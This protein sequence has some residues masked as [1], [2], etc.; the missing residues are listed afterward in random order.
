M[1]KFLLVHIAAAIF[2]KYRWF[3]VSFAISLIVLMCV[4]IGCRLHH[5]TDCEPQQISKAPDHVSDELLQLVLNEDEHQAKAE[6]EPYTLNANTWSQDT[7][8]WL[9]GGRH[10]GYMSVNPYKKDD[11]PMLDAAYSSWLEL[12]KRSSTPYKDYARWWLSRTHQPEIKLYDAWCH[13]FSYTA[14]DVP[15]LDSTVEAYNRW[16]AILHSEKTISTPY[17]DYARWWHAHRNTNAVQ[18][19]GIYGRNFSFDEQNRGRLEIE[20]Q[21]F[22]GNIKDVCILANSV[23]AIETEAKAERMDIL[24]NIEALLN[25]LANV[26][27]V[28][29]II[30]GFVIIILAWEPGTET[31]ELA[32]KFMVGLLSIMIG[33]AV[34]GTFNWLVATARDM[35]F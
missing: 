35:G 16:Q 27:E 1:M 2:W 12:R 6:H 9:I 8:A 31:K 34:P 33:L 25:I 19:Y 15:H 13:R 17:T 11:A 5:W 24:L 28:V 20:W 29:G 32:K 21:C 23:H 7:C 22:G 3:R 4:A 30:W 10:G 18:V 14:S 26:V